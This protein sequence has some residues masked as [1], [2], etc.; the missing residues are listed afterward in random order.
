MSLNYGT[1]ALSLSNFIFF[2][3]R[4]AQFQP[5]SNFNSDP[6]EIFSW[7]DSSLFKKDRTATSEYLIVNSAEAEI[8][9]YYRFYS[10]NALLDSTQILKNDT[11]LG[12]MTFGHKLSGLDNNNDD[13]AD[14]ALM[15]NSTYVQGIHSKVH[16]RNYP[17]F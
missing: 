4:I 10:F 6:I 1:K 8:E 5:K 12:I 14:L 15:S 17:R 16:L 11:E 3:E 13:E 9:L 2:N 7:L